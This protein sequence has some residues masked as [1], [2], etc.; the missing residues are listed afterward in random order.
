VEPENDVPEESPLLPEDVFTPRQ[1]PERDMFTRRNEPD[2]HGNPGLQDTLRE[3]LRERGGQVILYGDTG[4][5]KSTLLKYAAD[6]EGMPVLSIAATSKRSFDDLVDIAIREVTLERDVEVVRS[7]TTGGGF[8]GGVTSHI[9][10][11]GHLKNE[12]GQEVRVELIDRTPL[13]ALAE[14]MQTEGYRILSFDNFQNVDQRERAMFAQALEVLSDRASETGDVKM[15]VIG[16]ADDADT[17]VGGS[18]SVRR[19]TTEIGVP[20]MPDDEI[21]NIF[22][23][24]FRLL[25]LEVEENALRN[26]VF[27][28]DG[29]PYFAH[30]LGLAVAR[31]AARSGD[32]FVSQPVLEAALVRV[33]RE[34]EASFPKRLALAFEAGG[35]VQPR[36]RI[37]RTMCLSDR[38]EW[39]SGDVVEEYGELYGSPDDPGFLHAAL[40]ELVKPTRGSILARTGKPKHYVFRFSD[41]YLRPFLRMK[42]FQPEQTK[43]F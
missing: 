14:T 13:L 11:R 21:A 19:R 24:G 15:V 6:D 34:V 31:D 42:H 30:L 40:G 28:C 12:K 18:G 1:P 32:G 5:G 38:R 35:H 8:E 26:L 33:A 16:I 3:A 4:V 7:G 39:R 9:T 25:G 36:R 10:I 29:F 22:I 20:R 37:L 43:L 23:S 2:L 41:P 27:Y 17:L